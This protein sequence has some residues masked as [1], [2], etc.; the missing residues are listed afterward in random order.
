MEPLIMPAKPEDSAAKAPVKETIFEFVLRD[1][2]IKHITSTNDE[3]RERDKGWG[4]FFAKK[5]GLFDEKLAKAKQWVHEAWVI[6]DIETEKLKITH[7]MDYVEELNGLTY[8]GR[9]PR[10]GKK[11]ALTVNGRVGF[12][13][14]PLGETDIARKTVASEQID[15]LEQALNSTMDFYKATNTGHSGKLIEHAKKIVNQLFTLCSELDL[16]DKEYDREDPVCIY[17]CAALM[18]LVQRVGTTDRLAIRKMEVVKESYM[19]FGAKLSDLREL[20]QRRQQPPRKGFDEV[21]TEIESV[22]RQ[23]KEACDESRVA[24]KLPVSVAMLV[25]V[26]LPFS[27]TP[28]EGHLGRVMGW[29]MTEVK[30]LKEAALAETEESTH[31]ASMTH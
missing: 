15:V 13:S 17:A 7:Y 24:G 1:S 29:A 22:C 26:N 18:Y 28:S 31:V 20:D 21:L 23:N 30:A 8:K 9:G 12:A 10:E 4:A 16:L 6:G 27:L 11:L 14:A 2:L 19:K 5:A 3:V 25:S